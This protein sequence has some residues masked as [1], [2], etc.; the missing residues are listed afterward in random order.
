MK[1]RSGILL[2]IIVILLLPSCKKVSDPGVT[3]IK[4]TLFGGTGYDWGND[5]IKTN[6]GGLAMLGSVMSADGDVTV[7]KGNFDFWLL[8]MNSEGT[9][10]W[11]KSFGGSGYDWGNAIVQ[12]SGGDYVMAGYTKS[13]DGDVSGNHNPGSADVWVMQCDLGGT[14]GWKFI[15]GGTAEDNATDILATSDGGYIICGYTL[16]TDG[17]LPDT[18]S[19]SDGFIIK[20]NS[21][22]VKQWQKI[23]GSSGADRLCSLAKTA[24]GCFI[25][26]GYSSSTT[27]IYSGNKG[28]NDAWIVKFDGSGKVK[29]Q[30]LLGTAANEIFLS[31]TETP[32]GG[33]A[34]TGSY[35]NIGFNVDSYDILLSK[36]DSLGNEEWSHQLGGSSYDAGTSVSLTS[37]GTMIVTGMTASSD[38]ES[39][40]VRGG[41]DILFFNVGMDETIYWQKR[42]GGSGNDNSSAVIESSSGTY[43]ATGYTTSSDLDMPDNHGQYDCWVMRLAE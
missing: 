12:S 41:Y 17:D 7:N 9:R 10:V 6:D 8:K 25:A 23:L 11:D 35:C 28:G 43:A 3:I 14:G 21:S 33:F 39:S 42:C 13:N 40:S 16:S 1:T 22:G 29:W 18:V 4:S 24:D 30:K 19:G 5:I 38:I 26:S 27:G 31:I 15:W 20:L 32:D 2:S 36:L 37:A 34:A